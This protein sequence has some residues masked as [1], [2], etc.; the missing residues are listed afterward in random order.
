VSRRHPSPLCGC[1]TAVVTLAAS[2][3]MAADRQGPEF[4]SQTELVTVDVVVL[5]GSGH[6]VS[7]LGASDFVVMEDGKPQAVVAFETV[8]ATV[9]RLEPGE[10]LSASPPPSD[11]RVAS[12]VSAPPTRRTFAFVFDDLH[13]GPLNLEPSRQALRTFVARECRPG[14]ALALFTTSDRRF[15]TTTRGAEDQ[16]WLEALERLA[17]RQR[18]IDP[19]KVRMTHYEAMRIATFND[20]AMTERVARRRI[21]LGSPNCVWAPGRG[22]QGTCVPPPMASADEV[23]SFERS[24]LLKTLDVLWGATETLASLPGRKALILVSEG[25]IL[26][27]SEKTF[28]SV[29]REASTANVVIHFLDARGLPAG[30]DFF[31]AAGTSTALPPQ[32]IGPT[33]IA[34]RLEDDGA[35]SLAADTGGLVLQTNDLLAGLERVAQESRVYYLLGYAPTNT[36]RDGRYRKI[37]V[38]VHRDDVQV[39]ARKGY[40]ARDKKERRPSREPLDAVDR[41]LRDPFDASQIPLRLQ[42]FVMGPLDDGRLE[43][44]VAGEIDISSLDVVTEGGR[45]LARP[46]LTLATFSRAREA[47]RSDWTLDVTL[48]GHIEGPLWHPFLTRLE[49]K[50]GDHRA[51]LVAAS[52]PSGRIGSVTHD[53]L[54]PDPSGLRISTP[55]LSDTLT[56]RAGERRV[57]PVAHRSFVSGA[58]LHCHVELHG[59]L[60]DPVKGRRGAVASLVARAADGREWARVQDSPMVDEGRHLSKLFSIPLAEAPLGEGTLSLH[61]RDLTSGQQLDADEP[62]RVDGDASSPR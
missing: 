44:L 17:S 25:F 62:F 46:A 14:D 37:Q 4:P 21:I 59:A 50:P 61:V 31:Q 34:W 7:G 18:L 42:A 51:R 22:L 16:Q 1:L 40:F 58:T 10:P 39:R 56:A 57:L 6:P 33:L 11:S 35:E 3:A 19:V 15:W 53:F 29:R 48:A 26:D 24:A 20:T 2:V 23:Y 28:D 49:M 54:V 5:D 55:I 36:K 12:N 52:E 27:P 60:A 9:P 8:T 45:T 38:K 41:K 13:V 47:H 32:D 43:V 30:P